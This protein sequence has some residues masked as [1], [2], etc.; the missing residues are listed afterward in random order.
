MRKALSAVGRAASEDRE[1]VRHTFALRAYS[2]EDSAVGQLDRVR[3]VHIGLAKSLGKFNSAKL[4]PGLSVIV[5]LKGIDCAL[6]E[7]FVARMEFLAE[8]EK[9]AVFQLDRAVGSGDGNLDRFTPSV[10]VILRKTDE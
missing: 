7:R 8:E 4:L 2:T 3:L 5:T 6:L 9:L 10:S 1:L